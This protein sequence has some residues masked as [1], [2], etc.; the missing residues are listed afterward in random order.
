MIVKKLNLK[1]INPILLDLNNSL[2]SFHSPQELIILIL[3][4]FEY[5]VKDIAEL[6]VDLYVPTLFRHGD[7]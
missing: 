1:F 4:F 3:N 6:I 5:H 7:Q 2:H